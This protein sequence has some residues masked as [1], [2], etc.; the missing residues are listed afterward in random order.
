[1]MAY[2]IFRALRT[3]QIAAFATVMSTFEQTELDVTVSD[4]HEDGE[5]ENWA[6]WSISYGRIFIND[7]QVKFGR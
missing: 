2:P 3:H 7:G 1:V 5:R 6:E 4:I